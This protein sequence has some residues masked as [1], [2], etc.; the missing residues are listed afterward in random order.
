VDL[1]L[2]GERTITI[3]CDVIQADGGTRTAAITGGFVALSLAIQSLMT[4]G[5]LSTNPIVHQVASVSVGMVNQQAV[6]DLD[7]AED[8][9]AQTDMNVVMVNDGRFIEVQGTAEDEP[10]TLNE[11]QTMLALA[12]QGINE[13][14]ALQRQV[15]RQEQHS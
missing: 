13:L 8:S 15:L 6:L 3:D 5:A 2:L 14:F 12:Q 11:L 7:Y 9:T 1:T 10:Y 4:S